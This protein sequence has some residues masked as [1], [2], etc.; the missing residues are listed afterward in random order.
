[1][2]RRAHRVYG[3]ALLLIVFS[4]LGKGAAPSLADEGVLVFGVPSFDSN[5]DLIAST[6]PAA[7]LVRR[8]TMLP[9][10]APIPPVTS[11]AQQRGPGPAA[12]GLAVSELAQPELAGRGQA[13]RFRLELADSVTTQADL[14]R[15]LLRIR[16]GATF[17][18]RRG[19]RAEDGVASLES[20]RARGELPQV[21]SVALVEGSGANVRSD[22]EWLSV[23]FTRKLSEMPADEL[24][25]LTESLGRCP[26]LDSGVSTLFG[27]LSGLGGSYVAAG[28][29]VINDFTLGSR[30]ALQK[31]DGSVRYRAVAAVVEVRGVS[32]PA[33]G[34]TSLR[35]GNLDAFFTDDPETL[36]KAG[37]D[38]TLRIARC[39]IYTVVSRKGLL[40]PCHPDLEVSGVFYQGGK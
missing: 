26:V 36:A 9:L 25:G 22:E 40:L 14:S 18:S 3:F 20:C 11:S 27:S 34:L 31:V 21:A 7:Y 37:N 16:A 23:S 33:Q 1:M 5:L 12:P 38:E 4:A 8:F 17:R 35:S 2:R 28:P 13:G 24:N 19:V 10:I 32:A 29:F 6:A 30:Y 15:W 39:S